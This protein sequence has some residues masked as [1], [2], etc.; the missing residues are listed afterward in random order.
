MAITPWLHYADPTLA[1]LCRSPRGSNVPI[2]D[3]IKVM[4]D[5]RAPAGQNE[6]MDRDK[7]KVLAATLPGFS[8]HE[9]DCD[10]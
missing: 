5:P 10:E 4:D 2:S 1:P 9:L 8:W 7:L 3:T 6:P